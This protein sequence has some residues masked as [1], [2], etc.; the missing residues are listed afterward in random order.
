MRGPFTMSDKLAGKRCE[1]CE[2]GSGS[3]PAEEIN[4]LITEVPRWKK[5]RTDGV[6]QLR[7]EFHFQ[8]FRQAFA[9]SY[10]VAALAERENHH[11]AMLVEWGKVTV[12]WWTHK[13][14]GL[15]ENDFVMAA[16]TDKVAATT[17][18]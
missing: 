13:I 17:T 3:L 18:H 10:K 6:D 7:R 14:N 2:L 1:P 5:I 8:D 16:K 4:R 9:F 12:T 15:H 11:P